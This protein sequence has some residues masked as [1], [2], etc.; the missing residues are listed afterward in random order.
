MMRKAWVMLLALSTMFISAGVAGAGL[1]TI[2]TAT[3]GGSSYNLIYED[4][5]NLVWL[6]YSRGLSNWES[7]VFWAAGLNNSGV[8]TYNFN[9]GIVVSWDDVWRLPE[10]VD[11]PYEYTGGYNVTSSE[12]GHLYYVSLGN[13]GQYDTN[14]NVQSGW[15]LQN[16]GLF[17]NLVANVYSSGT[18]F[19]STSNLWFFNFNDGNQ[20]I[21]GGNFYAVA[22]RPGE[23]SAV[24][25]PAAVWLLGSGIIGLV[26]L[27]KKFSRN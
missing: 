4:V 12:M 16:E 18:K 6:D 17:S 21:G 7:H 3:Y 2:G 23:V 8:L 1:A 9:P 15:G 24:P 26:G 13:L 22:V 14:G 10:T 11:G 19:S 5:Q 25:I 27:R 20:G